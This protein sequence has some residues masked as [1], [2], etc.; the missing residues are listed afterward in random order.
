MDNIIKPVHKGFEESLIDLVDSFLGRKKVAGGVF[1]MSGSPLWPRCY[2]YN[3]PGPKGDK[4]WGE[5]HRITVGGRKG[6]VDKTG[7]RYNSAAYCIFSNAVGVIYEGSL[8]TGQQTPVS[9][10]RKLGSPHMTAL[11]PEVLVSRNLRPGGI[12]FSFPGTLPGVTCLPP[13]SA[14]SGAVKNWGE[15]DRGNNNTVLRGKPKVEKGSSWVFGTILSRKVK[16]QSRVIE[17]GNNH[18]T[19]FQNIMGRN[20]DKE[21]SKRLYESTPTKGATAKMARTEGETG[22]SLDPGMELGPPLMS[23]LLDSQDIPTTPSGTERSFGQELVPDSQPSHM[24]L[25]EQLEV[26]HNPVARLA[27]SREGPRKE[28]ALWDQ[29]PSYGSIKGER[30][31]SLEGMDEEELDWRIPA[32]FRFEWLTARVDQLLVKLEVVGGL[33]PFAQFDLKDGFVFAS[34]HHLGLDLLG[35]EDGAAVAEG[36]DVARG[37]HLGVP[38]RKHLQPVLLHQHL[39]GKKKYIVKNF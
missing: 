8:G 5:V 15:L 7:S 16:G 12:S 31:K 33:D 1:I 19:Y 13:G 38:A 17:A 3:D 28:G 10:F 36:H 37:E 32:S 24:G 30:P 23:D 34:G 27:L 2:N 21:K 9:G 25:E 4:K 22:E 20:K 11:P 6:T 35:G 18:I 14:I 29:E 39:T 26:M